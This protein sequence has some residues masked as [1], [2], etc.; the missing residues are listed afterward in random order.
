MSTTYYFKCDACHSRVWC[1]QSTTVD[2]EY[3]PRIYG[4]T[5]I[6][7]WLNLHV[8]HD[9]NFVSEHDIAD[10]EYDSLIEWEYPD[11]DMVG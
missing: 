7:K 3:I 11:K 4:Y 8:G 9:I 6:P 5:G 10:D 1:G 2:G